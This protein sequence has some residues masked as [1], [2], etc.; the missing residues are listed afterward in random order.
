MG[1]SIAY[2]ERLKAGERGRDAT[3]NKLIPMRL[4][5]RGQ[6][7]QFAAKSVDLPHFFQPQRPRVEPHFPTLR[8][9]FANQDDLRRR[10]F[11]FEV[12]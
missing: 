5:K 1:W 2:G 11:D 9:G 3:S 6:P 12:V 8:A 7:P 10:A 4:Q